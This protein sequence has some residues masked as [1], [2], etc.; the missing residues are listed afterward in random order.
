MVV[1]TC[2]WLPGKKVLISPRW[3]NRVS[4][5]DSKVYVNLSREAIKNASSII[6]TL[7]IRN[8]RRSFTIITIGRN[9]GILL[10][11]A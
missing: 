2:N 4:W 10:L 7:S 1:D 11:P 6:R 8:T 9:I 3:I 5:D